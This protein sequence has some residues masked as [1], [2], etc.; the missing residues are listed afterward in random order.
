MLAHQRTEGKRIHLGED[1]RTQNSSVHTD[2]ARLV[3]P[4]L[5]ERTDDDTVT[6]PY[7]AV[8]MRMALAQAA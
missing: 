3:G 2:V 1:G 8:E 7:E 6:V 5:I 4:G